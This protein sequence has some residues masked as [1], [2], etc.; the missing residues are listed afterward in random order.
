MRSSDRGIAA[1][2]LLVGFYLFAFVIIGGLLAV[3]VLA[4]VQARVSAARFVVFTIPVVLAL[5]RGVLTATHSPD[6][7]GPGVPVTP[8]MQPSLWAFVAG[9]AA[10]V[11]TRAPDE[12]RLVLDANAAVGERARMLGL[13]PGIRRMYLGVPLLATLTEAQLA[14]VLAHELGHYSHRDTRFAATTYR[15]REAL[16]RSLHHLNPK[17]SFQW[18]V[19]KFLSR[20]TRLYLR[21][22][23][24]VCR[25]Q[26]LAADM[27][28]AQIAGGAALVAVLRETPALGAAWALFMNHYATAGWRAGFLPERVGE[29]FR[30]FLAVPQHQTEL[31]RIRRDPPGEPDS[32]YDSHPPVAERV[33]AIERADSTSWPTPAGRPATALVHD[34]DTAFEMVL[35]N[36]IAAP[37]TGLTRV[38]WPEL[39]HLAARAAA[40]ESSYPLLDSAARL[41]ARGGCLGAVLDALDHGQIAG[42]GAPLTKV[43]D[44]ASRRVALEMARTAVREKLAALVV[45]ALADAGK[46]RWVFSWTEPAT[47]LIDEPYADGL[48]ADL[49][50]AVAERGS[51]AGLR[52]L[53]A[54]AMADQENRPALRPPAYAIDAGD[55][56]TGPGRATS[57]RN[58]RLDG[59]PLEEG[60]SEDGNR[61]AHRPAHSAP[62]GPAA[63]SGRRGRRAAHRGRD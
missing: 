55:S 5:G 25:R 37:D 54:A 34:P 51:T 22:S 8:A 52:A 15:G 39:M 46:A 45:V 6:D 13:R 50:A 57:G 19:G 28:A 56:R 63:G 48:A 16:Q 9:L 33:A 44:G 62:R 18:L 47:L 49:D 21:V 17:R 20:Y 61:Q 23:S 2:A 31:E 10:R 43:A 11:G 12:I 41:T 59:R 7:P 30:A 32:P 24:R 58:H 26:E 29:G 35:R 36:S 40:V 42:L 60:N 27:I 1:V 4:V 38:G 3:D 53:L 14:A